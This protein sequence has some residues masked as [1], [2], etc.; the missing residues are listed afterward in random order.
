MGAISARSII[1]YFALIFRKASKTYLIAVIILLFCDWS[2][3]QSDNYWSWT[4]NTPSTLLAGAVV[5]GSAGPSAVFYNPALIDHEQVPSLS[6]SASLVSLQF[7]DIEGIAGE[8]IDANKFIFKVQ[9]RFISYIVKNKNDRLG[10]EVA[11]LSPVSEEI[12]YTLQH[13]D[14]LDVINRTEGDETY[15]GYLNYSRKFDDTWAGMGFSYRVNDRLYFGLST[16]IS[17]KILRYEYTQKAEA[18]QEGDS[19]LVNDRLEPKYIAYNTFEEQTKY[20]DLSLVFK[21]GFQYKSKSERF[22]IGGNITFPNIRLYG[23]AD[24]R[25]SFAR[26]NVFDNEANSFTSN[27]TL[28][29]IEEKSRTRVKTPFST[30]LGLQYFTGNR[31][32]AISL[33]MEYFHSLD[34]YAVIDIQRQ[35]DPMSSFDNMPVSSADFMSYYHSARAVTN[36]GIG[37]KQFFS[38]KFTILGGFRTDFTSCK[39][40]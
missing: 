12:N 28:I 5:G 17:T 18:F 35:R 2:F 16:F 25:K 32:N 38:E 22:S 4:F 40:G 13:F 33:T 10:M 14:E 19:V 15:S 1:R 3:A 30:A 8:G 7:F 6:L 29:D 34:P 31:R 27:E 20:W 37:F 11:I 36:I 9:P 23:E 21:G 39:F 26:S 24:V